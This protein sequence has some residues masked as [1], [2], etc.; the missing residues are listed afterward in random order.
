M[1]EAR[2]GGRPKLVTDEISNDIRARRAAGESF[3]SIAKSAGFSVV[4]VQGVLKIAPQTVP[5]E[6]GTV[7]I[8]E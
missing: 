6:A 3:R 5:A 2:T 1:A 7:E 8:S 4:M